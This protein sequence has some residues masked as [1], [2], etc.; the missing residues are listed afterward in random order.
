M[1]ISISGSSL[2]TYIYAIYV[3]VVSYVCENKNKRFC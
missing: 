2:H 3:Y 1:G